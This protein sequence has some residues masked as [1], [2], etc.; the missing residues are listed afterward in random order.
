MQDCCTSD[1]DRV[2]HV[3]GEVKRLT[4][5]SGQLTDADQRAVSII[6]KWIE[7]TL[8][9]K[10]VRLVRSAHNAPVLAMYGS[11]GWTAKVE[12]NNSFH[13]GPHVRIDKKTAFA[14][15]SAWRDV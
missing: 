1:A 2:A 8:L 15:S 12:S 11:D 5:A 9:N 13:V 7:R 10:A 4:A 14:T 6:A 3:C